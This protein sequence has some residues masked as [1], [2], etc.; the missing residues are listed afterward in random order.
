MA[1]PESFEFQ[2]NSENDYGVDKMILYQFY[3]GMVFKKKLEA[4]LFIVITETKQ[5]G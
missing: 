1:K 4:I 5:N 3:L 2:E